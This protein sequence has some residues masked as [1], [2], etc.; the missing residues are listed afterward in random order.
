MPN[1]LSHLGKMPRSVA[2]ILSATIVGGGYAIYSQTSEKSTKEQID[3]IKADNQMPNG[4]DM[5]FHNA[6]SPLP[7]HNSRE[8]QYRFDNVNML[9]YVNNL[10]INPEHYIY[11]NYHNP[12][13]KSENQSYMFNWQG[14]PERKEPHK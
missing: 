14:P 7:Y 12:T 10:G 11:R 13:D 4:V 6:Y 8:L 1:I 3:L 5:R 9:N 2:L